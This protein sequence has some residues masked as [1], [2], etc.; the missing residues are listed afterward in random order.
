MI[1]A[2][3]TLISRPGYPRAVVRTMCFPFGAYFAPRL[4]P[5]AGARERR[6]ADGAGQADRVHRSNRRRDRGR[7]R[8]QVLTERHHVEAA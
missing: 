6:L 2:L 7:A 1:A 8:L 5:G 3:D 4:G